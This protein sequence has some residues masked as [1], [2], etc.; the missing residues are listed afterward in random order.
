[1]VGAE[2]LCEPGSH[3]PPQHILATVT[4]AQA[5]TLGES[6]V[7][8]VL[9]QS[10]RWGPCLS[11]C[12]HKHQLLDEQT[13]WLTCPEAGSA[14]QSSRSSR[15]GT[16]LACKVRSTSAS[17]LGLPLARHRCTADQVRSAQCLDSAVCVFA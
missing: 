16:R 11:D 9:V 3:W 13:S 2:P 14:R 6:K 7:Q 10:E 15:S 12:R 17:L 4:A 5:S 1:M 8:G